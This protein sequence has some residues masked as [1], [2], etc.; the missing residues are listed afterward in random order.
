LA[1]SATARG[2]AGAVFFAAGFFAFGLGN[3]TT[4][5]PG[6]FEAPTRPMACQKPV[7][8]ERPIFQAWIV[9]VP[10]KAVL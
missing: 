5:A 3:G 10:A 9:A 8:A 6:A 4:S 7:G 1:T 2:V